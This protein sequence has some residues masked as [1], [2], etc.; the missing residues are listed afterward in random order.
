MYVDMCKCVCV[1][2]F[3]YMFVCVFL[4]D[5]LQKILLSNDF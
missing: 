2:K 1:C 5:E 4:S 3:I